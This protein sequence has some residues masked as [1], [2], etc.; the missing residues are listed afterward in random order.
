[1]FFSQVRQAYVGQSQLSGSPIR[2]QASTQSRVIHTLTRQGELISRN[3]NQNEANENEIQNEGE[4][5]NEAQFENE[6]QLENEAD[7]THDASGT[8]Q[9]GGDL[10]NVQLEMAEESPEEERPVTNQYP[11]V[12][13]YRY[14]PEILLNTNRKGQ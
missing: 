1:M 11:R 2:Q 5:Q 4:L 12:I 8:N 14:G 9:N 7:F 3:A 10:E 13:E 6:G